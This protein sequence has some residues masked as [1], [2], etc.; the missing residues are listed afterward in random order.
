MMN[1]SHAIVGPGLTPSNIVWRYMDFAKFVDF[2]ETRSL[3]LTQ[4]D[5]FPD[6]FEGSFTLSIKKEIEKAYTENKIKFTYSEFKNKL[7]ERVYISCWRNSTTDSMAMW[8]LY[9][10]ADCALAITTTI[11]RIDQAVLANEYL[12]KTYIR[13]VKYVDYSDNPEIQISP[14]SNIFSYKHNAYEYEKEVRIIL[15]RYHEDFSKE[16]MCDS[17]LLN[18][19]VGKFLTGVII[20]PQAPDWFDSLVRKI[21]Y[22]YDFDVEVKKSK[23][24]SDP[25]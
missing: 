18:I 12:Y 19:D 4:A 16:S 17:V 25:I 9:G 7:R 5:K 6:K 13:K 10:Q 20:S 15:D 21:M 1:H 11:S 23:L 8:Q 14:Y 3:R 24:S 22:R 2:L